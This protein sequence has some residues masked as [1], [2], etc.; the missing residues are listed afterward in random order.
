[1]YFKHVARRFTWG[2]KDQNQRRTKLGLLDCGEADCSRKA[3]HSELQ[4]E[5]HVELRNARKA[6]SL[7]SCKVEAERGKQV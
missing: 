6:C 5:V 1:M 2:S 4:G 3:G 7:V